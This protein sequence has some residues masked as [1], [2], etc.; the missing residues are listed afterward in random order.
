MQDLQEVFSRIKEN[1]KKQKDINSIYRDA[2]ASSQSY[3]ETVEKIKGLREKKKSIEGSIRAD[4]GDELTK[5]EGIKLDL[6]TDK[7]LLS[8]IA[9]SQLM[10]GQTVE[11]RDE[12]ENEYEPIFS[13]KFKKT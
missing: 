5:L 10:K 7:E 3:Q 12:Y 4:F 1:Q 8:D 13:V 9:I 11:V 2:L 6:K